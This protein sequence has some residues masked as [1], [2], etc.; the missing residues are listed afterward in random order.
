MPRSQ[1]VV[2]VLCWLLLAATCWGQAECFAQEVKLPSEVQVVPGAWAIISPEIVSGGK[3]KWRVDQALTE[4]R[5]D[6]LFPPEIAK[7]ATGRV[8]TSVTPGRFKVECWNAKTEVPSDIA[9]TWVVV[10]GAAPPTTTPPQTP[11]PTTIP[12]T[13]PTTPPTVPTLPPPPAPKGAARVILMYEESSP[14]PPSAKDPAAEAWL[15]TNVPA[16]WYRWDDD[17]VADSFKAYPAGVADL[18][19]FGKGTR[20]DNEPTLVVEFKDGQRKSYILPE[21]PAA[22]LKLLEGF[23]P[24]VKAS[25]VTLVYEKDLHVI[26]S[27]VSAALNV[28]NR[29]GIIANPFEDDTVDGNGETPDQYKVPLA[30]AKDA[31][32]PASSVL[33]V[34]A[35]ATV[36]RTVKS[37]KTEQEVLEAVKP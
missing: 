1:K 30:A 34:T 37:P 17:Y 19:M 22:L 11:A 35:G 21:Q 4:V 12:P 6:L 23:S 29:Q 20:A 36:L 7:Q 2:A 15:H 5:L 32:F 8:F 9:V 27:Q 25:A 33:V 28:L 18:Y 24:L 31:G 3:P 13:T 10:V 16:S 14:A 26:P